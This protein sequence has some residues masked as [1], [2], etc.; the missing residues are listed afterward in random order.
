MG[1]AWFLEPSDDQLCGHYLSSIRINMDDFKCSVV[2]RKLLPH[3]FPTHHLQGSFWESLGRAVA[4]FGYLE[5]VLG[6]A[7][8]ALTATRVYGDPREL[9][10]AYEAWLPKLE[11]ALID[12]LASLIE[13]YRKS[14]IDHHEQP[15]ENF[16]KL[17]DD[18]RKANAIRNILCHGSWG[19]PNCNGA[20]VPHFVNRQKQVVTTAMDK[21][22]ID[23][24]QRYAANLA[25]SV[26][27]S[28]TCMGWQFP[29]SHSSGKPLWQFPNDGPMKV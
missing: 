7:I 5:E 17:L 3:Q 23:S 15:L 13:T 16:E 19:S 10:M 11:R 9:D 22:Y 6:K 8:Y 2:N 12:P 24:V 4:T 18:L 20:S 1:L 21:E 26:I 14:I 29:G 28:V 25:C 27:D